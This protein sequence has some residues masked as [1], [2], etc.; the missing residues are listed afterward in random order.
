M[1]EALVKVGFKPTNFGGLSIPARKLREQGLD[2]NLSP[3]AYRVN[4]FVREGQVQFYQ[5]DRM[6]AC[7]RWDGYPIEMLGN[8]PATKSPIR[9]NWERIMW[10]CM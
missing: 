5:M 2:S 6:G 8:T 1:L 7:S 4:V 10:R 3:S 9:G